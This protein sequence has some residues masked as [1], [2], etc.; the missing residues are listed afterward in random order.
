[1]DV[2]EEVFVG[3][4][5]SHHSRDLADPSGPTLWWFE[6]P[7]TAVVLG[8]TQSET[9]LDSEACRRHG[10]EVARRRSGG[11]LVIVGPGRVAWLDVMI[12][13]GHRLWDDDLSRSGIWL[14][15]AWIRGLERLGVTDMSLHEGPLTRTAWS[16]L[17]CFDGRGPGEVFLHDSKL[18]GVSQRRT[19]DWARFQCALS[20]R[21]DPEILGDVV[22]LDG[23]D[24][25]H[26]ERSGAS[27]GLDVESIRPAV[28]QSIRESIGA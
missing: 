10:I 3:T 2:R 1:M 22:R 9:I 23:F 16:G 20:L 24:V 26:V 4:A 17:V 28:S 15:Q 25:R 21:W 8:S 18:V 12:P 19:H 7:S 27:L 6:C 13:R 11:G 5:Q 14:A